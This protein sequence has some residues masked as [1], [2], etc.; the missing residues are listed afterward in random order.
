MNEGNQ[1]GFWAKFGEVAVIVTVFGGVVTDASE[2]DLFLH[3]GQCDESRR[4]L[5]LEFGVW[6]FVKVDFFTW[7]SSGCPL[8]NKSFPVENPTSC[9]EKL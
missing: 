7:F 2:V 8:G 5:V 1:F 3:S 6:M 9:V 4:E